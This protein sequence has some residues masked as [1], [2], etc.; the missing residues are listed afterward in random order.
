MAAPV[1]IK[2]DMKTLTRFLDLSED[3]LKLNDR[4]HGFNKDKTIHRETF[5]KILLML[6]DCVVPVY[7]ACTQ[8]ISYTLTLGALYKKTKN[9]HFYLKGSKAKNLYEDILIPLATAE[10]NGVLRMGDEKAEE[11]LQ[12][13]I[14]TLE[15]KVQTLEAKINSLTDA[16]DSQ[17]SKL[18]AKN[19]TEQQEQRKQHNKAVSG[20]EASFNKKLKEELDKQKN[21]LQLHYKQQ[22]EQADLLKTQ[23]ESQLKNTSDGNKEAR[24]RYD[25]ETKQLKERY[26]HAVSTLEAELK[27]RTAESDS[28]LKSV[29]AKYQ[30]ELQKLTAQIERYQ[31]E[32]EQKPILTPKSPKK[33]TMEVTPTPPPSKHLSDDQ[34]LGKEES[35]VPELEPEPTTEVVIKAPVSDGY[36]LVP[37]A[38]P[39]K[40]LTPLQKLHGD[41]P[42]F[43]YGNKWIH[44][45]ELY[46]QGSAPAPTLYNLK[47]PLSIEP[48]RLWLIS[49]G[50]NADK[51]LDRLFVSNGRATIMPPLYV[52][53]NRPQ[54]R[55]PENMENVLKFLETGESYLKKDS[56]VEFAGDLRLLFESHTGYSYETVAHFR[57]ACFALGWANSLQ[58]A[59]MNHSDLPV[60]EYLMSLVAVK[61]MTMFLKEFSYMFPELPVRENTNTYLMATARNP[62]LGDMFM[63]RDFFLKH[64]GQLAINAAHNFG[65]LDTEVI[66]EDINVLNALLTVL[67]DAAGLQV[68]E[69]SKIDNQTQL[70]SRLTSIGPPRTL[71]LWCLFLAD[72]GPSVK[73]LTPDEWRDTVNKLPTRLGTAY[74]IFARRFLENNHSLIIKNLKDTKDFKERNPKEFQERLSNYKAR[75]WDSRQLEWAAYNNAIKFQKQVLQLGKKAKSNHYEFAFYGLSKV[76]EKS[77]INVIY[78]QHK[79]HHQRY[80]EDSGTISAINMIRDSM[81]QGITKSPKPQE[82]T[83][84]QQE[85]DKPT[86]LPEAHPP[87]PQPDIEMGM[88]TD[89]TATTVPPPASSNKPQV[90]PPT[91]VARILAQTKQASNMQVGQEDMEI[92]KKTEE[93]LAHAEQIAVERAKIANLQTAALSSVSQRETLL[94]VK[95][96]LMAFDTVRKNPTTML[97][98]PT[99]TSTVA[100]HY[101]ALISYVVDYCTDPFVVMSLPPKPSHFS[102]PGAKYNHYTV[103]QTQKWVLLGGKVGL[104]I[105][106]GN[107]AMSP[108]EAIVNAANTSFRVN[109]MDGVSGALSAFCGKNKVSDVDK[110][111]ALACFATN[112]NYPGRSVPVRV[113]DILGLGSRKYFM[114]CLA[115]QL[116]SV[117]EYKPQHDRLH[118]MMMWEM[119]LECVMLKIKSVTLVLVGGNIYNNPPASIIP[120]QMRALIHALYTVGDSLPDGF[121]ITFC[122]DPCYHPYL[123]QIIDCIVAVC[124]NRPQ[125]KGQFEYVKTLYGLLPGPRGVDL[126]K[127]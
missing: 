9:P 92:D 116:G 77:R 43:I 50:V 24:Q 30:L 28:L 20:I 19:K 102:G 78:Q 32:H 25:L 80:Q 58:S 120:A 69:N 114:H 55:N 13:E 81:I 18:A 15:A 54:S 117:A 16:L 82:E 86:R 104:R 107:V 60:K 118:Q 61:N 110:R 68:N 100:R 11:A 97:S 45:S 73:F 96:T 84:K 6:N 98:M 126:I 125:P 47:M 59:L 7:G 115:P 35:L 56:F 38:D 119:V 72:V 17:K 46:R 14:K 40:G 21:A 70:M 36:K 65:G 29:N 105:A 75:K 91:P 85:P 26:D 37:Y 123:K 2:L 44:C 52:P 4:L 51:I 127:K 63:S 48:L 10:K 33:E 121:T 5:N 108:D 79:I 124:P 8:L 22:I 1:Y 83:I 49:S 88:E 57:A 94:K 109:G 67:S 34:L 23:L 41:G 99:L 101:E 42:Y 74:N 103:N 112:R 89:E 64:L 27:K 113:D 3:S 95:Q 71:L 39:P 90:T 66:Q 76:T 62:L 53:I 12:G 87:T 93:N 106:S 31:N 111:S 122:Y